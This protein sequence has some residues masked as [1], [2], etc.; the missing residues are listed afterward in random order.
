MLALAHKAA[1]ERTD[2]EQKRGPPGFVAE[3]FGKGAFARPWNA[4]EKNA[5]WLDSFARLQSAPAKVFEVGQAA[6]LGKRLR[7]AMQVEQVAF[8][9]HARFKFRQ[10]IGPDLVVFGQRQ[11]IRTFRFIA[12]HAS[13]GIEDSIEVFAVG[14]FIGL[15]TKKFPENSL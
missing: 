2:I 7:A 12:R 5:S 3:G 4:Q 11:G 14:H 15:I 13:T 9:E 1:Q 6:Q 10:N 8:L